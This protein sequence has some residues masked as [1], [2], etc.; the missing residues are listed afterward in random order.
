MEDL[1]PCPF[2]GGKA[3]VCLTACY[4]WPGVTCLECTANVSVEPEPHH[5][6]FDARVESVGKRAIPLWN[7]R[8]DGLQAKVKKLTA[9]LEEMR[10]NPSLSVMRRV[11]ATALE[12]K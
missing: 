6:D 1:K 8:A 5:I 12:D 2:C 4:D 11:T 7:K 9:A 10:D 3:T